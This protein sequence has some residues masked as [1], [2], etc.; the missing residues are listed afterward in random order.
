MSGHSIGCKKVLC[1]GL[2][3]AFL[4]GLLCLANWGW[5]Q[6]TKTPSPQNALVIRSYLASVELADKSYELDHNSDQTTD[7]T[8][9]LLQ[10]SHPD[11]QS[12]YVTM[13]NAMR[14]GQF[15]VRENPGLYG[16][17]AAAN[18]AVRGYQQRYGPAV[19]AMN[20]GFGG[21]RG[22]FGGGRGG[23]GGG[24]GGYGGGRG[25]YGGSGMFGQRGMGMFGGGQNRGMRSSGVFGGGRGGRGGYGSG[26][27]SRGGYGSGRSGRG[28]FGS[29]RFGSSR[30]YG[31]SGYGGYYQQTVPARGNSTLENPSPAART[32]E[33]STTLPETSESEAQ[34]FALHVWCFEKGRIIADSMDAGSDESFAF[35]GMSS[36]TVR[37]QLITTGM[38]TKAHRLVDAEL[39]R[40]GVQSQT[41]SYHDIFKNESIAETIKYYENQ[42]KKIAAENPQSIG[43]IIANRKGTI[44]AADIYSSP[45]LF[46]QMLPLLMQSAALEVHQNN[47]LSFQDTTPAPVEEFLTEIKDITAWQKK[48]TQ[49]YQYVTKTLVGE[50]LFLSDDGKETFVHLEMYPR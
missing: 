16:A 39:K 40:L 35:S 46:R 48:T 28:G 30:G 5:A 23:F 14:Q 21:S 37:R 22:G 47:D 9:H 31:S 44:L 13:A 41:A 49:S 19:M 7:L 50:G 11:L 3:L 20:F 27:G 25:G 15:K 10:T 43:L 1:L 45:D 17:A 24:R 42:A 38:Q 29:G 33:E 36:P 4:L 8:V 2:I 12:R 26:R 32:L 6:K 34:E 18:P